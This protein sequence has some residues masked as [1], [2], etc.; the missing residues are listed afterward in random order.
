[1]S[2]EPKMEDLMAATQIEPNL[3]TVSATQNDSQLS[4]VINED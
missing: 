4:E 1:M 3:T 2:T